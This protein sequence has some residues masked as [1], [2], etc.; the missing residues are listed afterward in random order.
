MKVCVIGAG[1]SGLTT[2]KQLR[3][4][5]HEVLCFERAA[6]IGGIWYRHDDDADEMKVYDDLILTISMR[7]MCFSD[8]MVRGRRFANRRGYLEYLQAYADKFRLRDHIK[9]GTT[10]D[11]I[12]KVGDAWV[13][14]VTSRGESSEHR[15]DAVAVC[16]GPF[17]KP[18]LD[19]PQIDKFKGEVTHSSRY[20]NNAKYRGK[21]VLVVGLAESG[22]DI[23]REISDVADSCTL[24]IRQRS[25]LLPRLVGGKYSTD[26]MTFRAGHHEMYVRSNEVPFPMSAI[27]EDDKIGRAQFC[28]AARLH[29][30]LLL[31]S[32]T[33]ARAAQPP[34]REGAAQEA[35]NLGEP[36]LPHK[37][38]LQTEH[39]QQHLDFINEWNRK[40]H[41]DQGN[42]A[43]K[44]IACKNVSFVP[45]I[46]N[47]KIVVN[48]SGIED[49]RDRTVCFK[50]GSVGEFDAIVL[51][52][53][54][55]RDFSG[56]GDIQVPENNVRN[57]YKHAFHPEHG[58]RLALIGHVRPYF[59]G[60]PLCS[61]M[62]AR[63]FAQLCSGKLKLP[64]DVNERIKAERAWE[65]TW[66]EF[67]PSHTEAIPSQALFCDAIANEIGCLPKASDLI[68]NPVLLARL[69]FHTF[70]QV[71]YR[72]VGPHSDHETAYRELM[73]DDLPGGSDV[74]VAL[75]MALSVCPAAFHPK[76]VEIQNF[77]MVVVP[78]IAR[79]VT[80][81]LEQTVAAY[82]T[83]AAGRVG[84]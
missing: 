9:F 65:E 34:E 12:Q 1:P 10:V 30:A 5:E 58:G 14:R 55:K 72:L 56:L 50:D 19:V 49:V 41:H 15:F 60:I 17:S 26:E 13:V 47:G 20:R 62:Q 73:E 11:G 36:M 40:A 21:R 35:N 84:S 59:G 3:D 22:A 28:E 25:M 16:S 74:Y 81:V 8:L 39:T 79:E 31:A 66:T 61:E 33:I 70:N 78:E 23:L 32:R 44:V 7:M 67:S 46:V 71:S 76:D 63:Y 42:Y 4:E 38:D 82:A 51:C 54:F 2:I 45:N 24:S 77:P 75:F 69:W 68:G 27:F 37:L 53:G 64:P 29:G 18:Q 48:D 52:T 80:K 83:G 43:L 57:L 6:D